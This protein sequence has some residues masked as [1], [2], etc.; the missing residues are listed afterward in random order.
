MGS[1]DHPIKTNINQREEVKLEDLK[2]YGW[3]DGWMDGVLGH[4]RHLEIKIW[5]MFAMERNVWTRILRG[6]W[7][8]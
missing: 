5:W 2:I 7:P 1:N 6:P 3:M 8:C 4:S